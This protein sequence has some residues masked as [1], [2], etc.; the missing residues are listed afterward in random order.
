MINLVNFIYKVFLPIFM[1]KALKNI[2]IEKA[3]LMKIGAVPINRVKE[4]NAFKKKNPNLD[5]F[6]D[7][8]DLNF[9][10]KLE[11]IFE[12]NQNLI[13]Y[14]QIEIVKTRKLGNYIKEKEFYIS[15]FTNEP[16]VLSFVVPKRKQKNYL[17]HCDYFGEKGI[18]NSENF[19]VI[20]DGSNYVYYRECDLSQIY[21]Q[22]GP[23]A[24][25]ELI[26]TLTPE[27]ELV[28]SAPNPLREDFFLIVTPHAKKEK[29]IYDL[30]KNRVYFILDK[31]TDI[32]QFL[33]EF[34]HHEEFF[35]HRFYETSNLASKLDMINYVFGENYTHIF[36]LLAKLDRTN[37]FNIFEKYQITKRIKKE[38]SLLYNLIGKHKMKEEELSQNI[39]IFSE[40]DNYSL[41]EPLKYIL[42]K[43]LE[44]TQ[45][46]PDIFLQN[47]QIIRYTI[48]DYQKSYHLIITILFSIIS[49]I[50]GAF[51][52]SSLI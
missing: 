23:D 15:S 46:H 25:D 52:Y 17:H 51:I 10:R 21:H 8:S 29:V 33:A 5:E 22:G 45:L 48:E 37:Y 31:K 24:R 2:K 1:H 13:D 42:K 3:I 38:F 26:S 40:D 34:L 11:K 44:Y 9:K 43:D 14:K 50:F 35:L 18:E 30:D 19:N 4:F 16:Y 39:K 20:Y 41:L 49:A 7:E 12:K 28:R 32:D 6:S 27:F 36:D 47:L